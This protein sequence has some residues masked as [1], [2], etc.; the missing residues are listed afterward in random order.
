VQV[1]EYREPY[2]HWVVQ[3]PVPRT[4]AHAALA[5]ALLPGRDW[6]Y[7]DNDCER[8][9]RTSRD[10]GLETSALPQLFE[11]L[12]RPEWLTRLEHL[13]GIQGLQA[14]ITLHGAGLHVTD[15]GGGLQPHLDYALHPTLRLERR[16][17][18]I[19]FLNDNWREE[20]GGAF[21][22]WDDAARQVVKCIQPSFN[23]AILWPPG[24]VEFHGTQ[25]TTAAAPPRITVA[26]YY[27]AAPRPGCTRKR[28]LFVP[29]RQR[30]QKWQGVQ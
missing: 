10:L 26:L 1:E 11:L 8:H 12:T 17:N 13:T 15:P 24:D 16:V 23:R 21:E 18:L 19:L 9:K 7:Y 30:L 29:P 4:L 3:D 6:V 22:L 14:D 28:A 27:L 2:R 5:Q 25:T 20:W